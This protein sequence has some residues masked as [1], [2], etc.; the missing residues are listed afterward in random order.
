MQSGTNQG[1]EVSSPHLQKVPGIGKHRF[2]DPPL[3]HNIPL[4]VQAARSSH[5]NES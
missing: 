1:Q 2:Q 5:H 3:V 4:A